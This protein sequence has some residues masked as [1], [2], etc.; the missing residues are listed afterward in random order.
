MHG[1]RLDSI[2]KYVLKSE[3]IHSEPITIF[4]KEQP[5]GMDA[6]RISA[7]GEVFPVL[8]FLVA[9]LVCLTGMTRMVEEE[10]IQIGTFKAL[11][12]SKAMITAKYFLYAFIASVIGS[13]IGILIGSSVLP[14]VIMNAYGMLYTT[15][16]TLLSP[17][18]WS[19]ALSAMFLAVSCVVLAAMAACNKTLRETPA[20]LMRPT[21]PPKGKRVFLEYIRPLWHRMSFG[22][23][24]AARNLFRYKKR[25]FMTIFGI[26]GCTALL[27]V[28][29]GLKDSIQK[30]VDT[31]YSSVWTY[32][33]SLTADAESIE[34]VREYMLQENQITDSLAVKQNALNAEAN[35]RTIEAYLFIPETTVGLDA[36]I[37]LRDRVTLE[38]HTLDDTGVII[39]EKMASLMNLREGDSITLCRSE[40]ERFEAPVLAIAENY[41]YHYVYMTPAYYTSLFDESPEYTQIFFHTD[42]L[43]ETEELDLAGRLLSIDEVKSV[44]LVS[45]LQANV[46]NMMNAMNLVIWVLIIAAGLLAFI[47]LFN[48]NNISILERRRELAT[49]RVLGFYDGELAAYLYRENVILTLLGIAAGVFMGIPL[50]RYIISTLEL[51]MIMFGRVIRPISYVFSVLMTIFFAGIVNFGMFFTLRKIDMVESLKSVE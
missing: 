2:P 34:T 38:P 42:L 19:S 46:A 40:T 50:H 28:G 6:E 29:F 45:S 14:Y 23:K 7:I 3:C 36:F 44:S 37:H 1:F 16:T 11:G 47:V 9:A 51:D 30:I 49:L 17:I 15:L 4:V 39:T 22:Q 5:T 8:F 25:L 10:R 48:L 13:I 18:H 21:S 27:V 26:A 31:Q 32:D 12:Y 43:N 35:G 41:L 33:A 20:S 24:A